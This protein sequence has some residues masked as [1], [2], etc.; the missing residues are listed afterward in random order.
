M[1]RPRYRLRID[2]ITFI[3]IFVIAIVLW[4]IPYL[5]EL[6]IIAAITAILYTFVKSLY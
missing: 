5:H 3:L 2:W 1:Q 6:L 4:F